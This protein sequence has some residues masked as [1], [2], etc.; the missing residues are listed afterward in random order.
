MPWLR[1]RVTLTEARNMAANQDTT[2]APNP[3]PKAGPDLKT[4]V[5]FDSLAENSPLLG[6][7]DGEAVVLVR[8]GQQVFAIGATCT[9]YSGPLAEGLVVG[10]TIHCPWHHARFSLRTGEAEGAPALSPVSCFTVQRDGDKVKAGKKC[11]TNAR[12]PLRRTPASVVIIGAGAAGAAC[13]DML[14]AKGYEGPI[15]L[16]GN[17]EPGP[18][19]RP[20]LS[21][22][23]L[24]GNA[25]EE[26]IPLRTREYYE[27]IHVELI[28]NDP[29]RQIDT[30]KRTTTLHSGRVLNY[31]ALLLATGAEPRSLPIEG[32]E[33]SHVFKLRTLA[34]SKAIIVRAT[35]VKQAVVIG[36]SF[37]GL[38]AAASLRHRGL[39]VTVVGQEKIP[40]ERVLGK[41]LSEFVRRLHEQNGVHFCL[42]DSPRVIR[43]TSVE[44]SSGE[45]IEAGLVVLGVGVTPRTALAE[46]AG[47][48]ID[49]G[50]VVDEN[51]RAGPPDVYAAGDVARYPD[52]ISGDRVRI[53]HWVVAE[54][55]GQAVARAMLGI[56]GPFRDVPFFWSQHYDVAINYVGHAPSW[57]AVELQG[58]LPG[59]NAAAIYRRKGRTLAVATIG[60]DRESLLAEEQLLTVPR[61]TY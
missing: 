41:E 58:D 14:R 23:Y 15:T 10:E 59:R 33:L 11:E 3:D 35:Q 19:D 38:E 36:A 34:D 30:A 22:D 18:V 60:R 31:G 20:N 4:G 39:E 43:Q 12:V 42:G 47:L 26:W 61:P 2:L 48:R 53:E 54:R 7:V 13:A 25:P 37:I 44:L 57:D 9:H 51:L 1:R 52:P 29:A 8:Q 40:L 16:V 50:V 55:Q 46:K 17:E 28:P 56:G 45:S 24:A 49:N 21:K 27:S 32:A 5:D 6:H